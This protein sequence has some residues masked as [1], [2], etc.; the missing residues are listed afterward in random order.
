ME[1]TWA[2]SFPAAVKAIQSRL[3]Q[4]DEKEALEKL[5][6]VVLDVTYTYKS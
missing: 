5:R 6:D 3:N 4:F 2:L 1:S